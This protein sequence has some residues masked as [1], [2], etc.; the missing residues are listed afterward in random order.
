MNAIVVVGFQPCKQTCEGVDWNELSMIGIV[1]C[2]CRMLFGWKKGFV[3]S[4]QW[5]I[6][7]VEQVSRILQGLAGNESLGLHSVV[8][9][10]K[11]KS[12]LMSE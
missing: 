9:K 5:V 7:N 12:I 1:M 10:R 3:D 6:V 4:G 2:L 11:D 8:L